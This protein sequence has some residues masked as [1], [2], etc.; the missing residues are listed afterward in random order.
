M[1]LPKY[2][3]DHQGQ[4]NRHG[5]QEQSSNSPFSQ[6]NAAS[7]SRPARLTTQIEFRRPQFPLWATRRRQTA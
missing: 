3:T 5:G 4:E 1:Q 7:S 6:S 2:A